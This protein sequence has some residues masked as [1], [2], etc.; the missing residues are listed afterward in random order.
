MGMEI[1]DVEMV[2]GIGA[3]AWACDISKKKDAN[4]VEIPV[5]WNNFT[6]L[7]ITRPEPFVF[8]IKPRNEKRAAQIEEYYQE[9]VRNDPHMA[10]PEHA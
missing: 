10:M 3:L 7:L 4:G 6:D 8:D 9:A 5:H 2:I 1:V